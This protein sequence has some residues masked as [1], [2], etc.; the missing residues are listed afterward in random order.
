[1]RREVEGG[2]L[3]DEG[4]CVVY[5]GGNVLEGWESA[6]GH[7]GK[8]WRRARTGAR[9]G[10]KRSPITRTSRDAIASSC[11]AHGGCGGMI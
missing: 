11:S 4:D 2:D 5:L 9:S 3:E 7:R 10:M 1:M 6:R 8:S